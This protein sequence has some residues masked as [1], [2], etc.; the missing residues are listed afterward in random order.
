VTCFGSRGSSVRIWPH[1]Q[2]FSI[3]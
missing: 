3:T 1:R 2:L